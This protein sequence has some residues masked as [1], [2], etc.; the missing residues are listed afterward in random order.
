[1]TGMGCKPMTK[2]STTETGELEINDPRVALF[3][4]YYTDPKS[5]SFG[6]VQGSALRAGYKKDHARNITVSKPKWFTD[7]LSSMR[8]R[9]M[10]D[11]AER[12]LEAVLEMDIEVPVITLHGVLK[13]KKT[14]KVVK[15]VHAGLL[16]IRADTDKFVLERLNRD[17]YGRSESSINLNQFNFYDSEKR[18]KV[19]KLV[20]GY[21]NS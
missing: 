5:K 15:Q 16:K 6:S 18:E 20:S 10:L 21:L 13:D 4:A 11:K 8:Q 1:M 12:N 7:V 9:K 3:T 14:G 19:K 17:S 2:T